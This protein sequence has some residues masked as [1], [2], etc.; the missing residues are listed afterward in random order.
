MIP[1]AT[2]RRPRPLLD[3]A[4]KRGYLGIAAQAIGVPDKQRGT[5]AR[6]EGL[7]VMGVKPGSPADTAGV[8][9]GD[10]LL[11][12]DDH[13]LTT[14][15]ELLDLLVGDRVSRPATLQLIRGQHSLSVTVTV[16]ERAAAS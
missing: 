11:A 1:A 13:P 3:T 10:I 5:S 4:L 9:V 7:L 12:L 2:A 6:A 14:P 16:A 15:E 8:L